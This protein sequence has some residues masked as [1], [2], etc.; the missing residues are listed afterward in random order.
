MRTY[1]VILPENESLVSKDRVIA[2]YND[3]VQEIWYLSGKLN[4]LRAENEAL[5]KANE[6]LADIACG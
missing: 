2:M 3:A 4:Q 5:W 1:D 6:E